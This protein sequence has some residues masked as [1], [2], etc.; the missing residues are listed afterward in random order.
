MQETLLHTLL[1]PTR[2]SQ[3]MALFEVCDGMGAM[4]KLFS[5]IA[6]PFPKA[7]LSDLSFD[8]APRE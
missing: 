6:P 4:N 8:M 3:N 1:Y 5:Q 2:D 7:F